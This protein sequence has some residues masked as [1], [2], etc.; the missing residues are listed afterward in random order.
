MPVV[1]TRIDDRLIHGQVIV[2][3]VPVTH[4]N[5]I[6]VINDK[7]AKDEMQKCLMKMAV[8]PHIQAVIYTVDG[9][10]LT[11]ESPE[12]KGHNVLVLVT[13]PKDLVRLAEKGFKPVKINLGGMRH[14]TKKIEY[15]KSIFLDDADIEDFTKLKSLGIHTEIQM[16]P[17]D[18]PVDFFECLLNRQCELKDEKEKKEGL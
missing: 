5:F 2:G 9:F 17:T 1:L 7:V 4:A 11:M 15:T 10:N 3:W 13:N 18:K 8:P 14:A 12:I 6:I 16:V